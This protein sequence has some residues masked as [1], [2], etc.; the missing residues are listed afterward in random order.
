G[1]PLIRP[2]STT[3]GLELL[4]A[5]PHANEG[6]TTVIVG[7]RTLLIPNDPYMS[8]LGL[9]AGEDP[10]ALYEVTLTALDA[11]S[12]LPT[13]PRWQRKGTEL[14]GD[15]SVP[16]AIRPARVHLEVDLRGLDTLVPRGVLIVLLDLLILG[17]VWLLT[18]TADGG[19]RRWLQH[20]IA[21][22]SRS[23]RARL[24]LT[25]FSFFVLPATVFGGWSYL[26]LQANDRQSRELLVRETL[27][28][29]AATG[30]P[31]VLAYESGRLGTP[32]FLYSEGT[33]RGVSDPLYDRLSPIGRYLPPLVARVFA[34]ED[35]VNAS[36][37]V[38]VGA[39]TTLFGYRAVLGF[40]E[41][42]G[43]VL[44][45]PARVTEALLDRQRRDLGILVLF[46]IA[47]GATAA[48]WLSGLAARELER[49]IGALRAAA[50]EIARGQRHP[51][52][53]VVPPAEFVPVFSAFRR[54]DDDL[55]A[56]REALETAQRQ[57]EAVLRN[58]ASGVIAVSSDLRVVLANPR[59]EELLGRALPPG[60][61]LEYP[62]A[63]LLR[64][65][66]HALLANDADEESFDV[67]VRG[68]QLRANLTRL[69]RGGGG[70]VLTLDDVTE[71]ARA[72][73]VLA[74]G[75]M[76]RQ[77]AHEIKNPLTPIRLGVQHLRRARIDRHV[78]FERI[79][80][81][82]VTRILSEIDRLDEIAR[83]FSRYGTAPAERPPA[84]S[85]DVA[86]IVRDVVELEQMGETV[87][88][89]H[90]TGADL[91]VLVQATPDEL[92]EVL[93]NVFENARQA[94][95]TRVDVSL[96]HATDGVHVDIRDNGVGMTDDVLRR[97]FEPHFSTRT[98]GSGLGLAISRGLVRG[99]GGDMFVRST[100]GEGTTMRL[101]LLTSEPR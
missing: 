46:A 42:R 82:N 37:R 93:L 24:T 36:E 15:A 14:H 74:W 62:A 31:L 75:E 1:R 13:E 72:Q 2:D 54:M 96:R 94:Q 9:G 92:R 25:L 65:R 98:S 27:R 53:R 66:A 84:R 35:E 85:V 90:V 57:T 33:L 70:A 97:I 17:V 41:A 20:R 7:P 8:L 49:P 18:V 68:R 100:P 89:W 80:E 40:G 88:A 6:V 47:L 86:A 55:A 32:L 28:S 67:E 71:V 79:F 73:R 56:S 81:Q 58:V 22:F 101:T 29:I 19:V 78:D 23:Y 11:P 45:A 87:V 99:W 76:A 59:A 34:A 48:L 95:A 91:P 38:R 43:A 16:A 10:E 39:R 50:L 83:A 21:A 61:D 64:D 12:S 77:V 4:L 3:Y 5:V 30:D 26:R 60:A 69:R 52:M 44:A 51:D 63:P